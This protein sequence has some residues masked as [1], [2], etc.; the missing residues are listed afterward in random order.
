M[1]NVLKLE[2]I[3]MMGIGIYFLT[4]HNLNLLI[5]I[6]LLIF[7]TPDISMLGYLVNAKVGAITYNIFHHKGIAIAC[8]GLGFFLKIEVMLAIGILLFTHS[9][10]DRIMGY[11]LKYYSSFNETHLGKLKKVKTIDNGQSE[12]DII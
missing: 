5:W 11:G 6:W 4:I 12:L 3:A 1:K 10:F 8:V 7:F 2:E 9:S